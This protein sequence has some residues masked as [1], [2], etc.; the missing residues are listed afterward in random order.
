MTTILNFHSQNTQVISAFSLATSFTHVSS[1]P[2]PTTVASGRCDNCDI[3]G[4]S[5]RAPQDP[6]AAKK[7]SAAQSGLIPGE[8]HHTPLRFGSKLGIGQ[9]NMG[10]LNIMRDGVPSCANFVHTQRCS[11]ICGSAVNL[12]EARV[13]N[14]AGIR[15]FGITNN[16]GG[17]GLGV[18][19]Y[20][21]NQRWRKSTM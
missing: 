5:P 17:I 1:F 10:C 14:S 8:C 9:S 15:D 7:T 19:C 13:Q 11:Q 16:C 18:S 12:S 3:S 2:G 4:T 20:T 6:Q 21:S